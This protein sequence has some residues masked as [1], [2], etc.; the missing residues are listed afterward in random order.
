[1]TEK[2]ALT[3]RYEFVLLFDVENGNP[4]GD[5]DAGNMPRLDAET[6]CGLV[7]DVCLKRKVRNYIELAKG[8][9][10]SFEIYVKES[11]VLNNLNKEAFL[12][13]PDI[14]L[15]ENKQDKME[16]K[17]KSDQLTLTRW[18][19]DKYYDIRTFGAV[20]TTGVNCGQVRGPVQFS[21][22]K[23]IDP[24]SPQ[25]VTITRMAVTNEKDA[26]KERTMGRKSIVPYG[27]YRME[28]YVSAPLANQTNFTE[29]DLNELWI[30]LVN[31]FDHD[32]SAS[33]GKMAAQ[34][35]IVFEHAT[36]LG[37]APAHKLFQ[38]VKVSRK[39]GVDLARSFDDYEVVIGQ[40]P[41]GVTIDE[42]L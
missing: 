42:K 1:M 22:S 14:E 39:P 23:S 27:L 16:A 41:S 24:I 25:E 35:L 31:M 34:K 6:G 38:L 40:A 15:K 5:P 9:E 18:M 2:K 13:N 10:P 33:R 30:A 20:M 7:T 12:N 26:D 37:N 28:G 29:E 36:A 17:K 8:G 32:R 3:K 4:N 19:C 11:A 21:F